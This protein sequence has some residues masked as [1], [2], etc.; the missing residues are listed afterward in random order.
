VVFWS[1]GIIKESFALAGLYLTAGVWLKG[2]IREK[3]H[4]WEYL[5]AVAGLWVV[6]NLKYYWAAVF[7]PVAAI[8]IVTQTYRTR[9]NPITGLVIWPLLVVIIAVAVQFI[10]PN[11]Y[12]GNFLNVLVNNHNAF[13]PLSDPKNL[14]HYYNL[15]PSWISVTI[16]SPWALFSGLFRPLPGEAHGILAWIP[17]IENA[18]ILILVVASLS[19]HRMQTSP[20][21]GIVV[22]VLVYSF[23]LCVFLSLST[24]NFGSLARYKVGFMPF[25]IFVISYG[26]PLLHWLT[27]RLTKEFPQV[28]AHS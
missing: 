17:A 27:G 9:V 26:N 2:M 4:F 22:S 24:P 20:Y 12:P 28:G 21:K 16:N 8:S 18:V 7:L 15:H 11:F 1:S 5:A 14:I 19:I 23:V 6:W 10:H 25:F 13:I 3:T